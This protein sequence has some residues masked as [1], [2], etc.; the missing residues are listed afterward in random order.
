MPHV[1]V[2]LYPGTGEEE[3]ATLATA[4]QQAVMAAIGAKKDA[5]SVSI[6]E[7]DAR[8]WQQEVYKKE[9]VKNAQDVYIKPGYTM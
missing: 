5:V 8:D 4:I 6:R 2:R 9:I 3:K 1:T 7:V